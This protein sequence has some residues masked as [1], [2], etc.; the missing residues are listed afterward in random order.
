MVEYSVSSWPIRYYISGVWKTIYWTIKIF[1]TVAEAWVILQE[2]LNTSEPVNSFARSTNNF[3]NK[4]QLV[5][6]S[7]GT[8]IARNDPSHIVA[9]PYY[10]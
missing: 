4:E 1:R 7:N 10:V 2:Y 9:M 3:P 5:V 8:Y 6:E